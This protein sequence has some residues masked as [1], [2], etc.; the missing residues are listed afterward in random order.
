[1]FMLELKSCKR[2][3]ATD[4]IK[5]T[6]LWRALQYKNLA[7]QCTDGISATQNGREAVENFSTVRESNPSRSSAAQLTATHLYH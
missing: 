1:M 7:S 2:E 6:K 5:E 3:I 4:E